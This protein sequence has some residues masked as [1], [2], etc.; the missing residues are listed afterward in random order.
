MILKNVIKH[1]GLVTRHKWEV[2]KLSIK[3]GIPIRGILHDLSKFSP[4]EFKESV[5]YYNGKRSPISMC[6]ESKGYSEAW[7]HHKGRNK[8]HPEYWYDKNAPDSAPL[9]PYKYICEMICDQ[10]SAGKVYM[11][12]EWT[13][14]HQIEY[15]RKQKERI[16]INKNVA[17]LLTTVYEQVAEHGIDKTITKKNIRSIYEKTCMNINKK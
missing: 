16:N 1:L 9:I 7:L 5:K 12:K 11:G 6:K 14:E 13:K 17:E 4:I 2:F 8:H 15:W 3:L 10:L